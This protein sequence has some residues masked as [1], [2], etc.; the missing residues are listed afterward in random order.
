MFYSFQRRLKSTLVYAVLPILI[1]TFF[2]CGSKKDV[3][4]FQDATNFETL[5][6]QNN[7]QTKFKIDDEISIIVSTLN[8]EASVPFNLYR[9]IGESGS[10]TE[11]SQVSYLV[12]ERGEIDFP[13]LGKIKVVGLTPDE[14]RSLLQRRLSSYLK[15]PIIN[16][17]LRNFTVTVLGAVNRPGTYPVVGEQVSILEA[18][19]L[20]GD[21][22]LKGR[23]DNILVI[24]DF[25]GA[26]VYNRI[27]LT[28]KKAMES[29]VFY[30]NQNDVVYVEPNKS[31]IVESVTDRRVSLYFSLISL[32]ITSYLI[33]ETRR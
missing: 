7:S 2:S 9:R 11:P 4:Y 30:L 33:I 8:P 28:S 18:L 12:D 24:S 20:A 13:V 16:I 25:N 15:D 22:A 26:K 10:E 3:V 19:G 32:A 21:L 14:L 17:R 27:D 5:V 29:P 1:L 6:S 31:A 23:R